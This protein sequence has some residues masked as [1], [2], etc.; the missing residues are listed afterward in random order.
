M[1]RSN[2]GSEAQAQVTYTSALASDFHQT[3]RQSL[4]KSQ[5]RY[6]SAPDDIA[7][8]LCELLARL[9]ETRSE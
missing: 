6:Y 4:T 1:A 2:D 9:E 7:P 5:V 8:N 3:L